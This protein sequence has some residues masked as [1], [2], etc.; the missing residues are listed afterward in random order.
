[1]AENVAIDVIDAQGLSAWGEGVHN[2]HDMFPIRNGMS[3]VIG[4]P[5]I[6]DPNSTDKPLERDWIDKFLVCCLPTY[7]MFACG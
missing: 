1:M 6:P 5:R 7:L 3:E 2:T 4:L